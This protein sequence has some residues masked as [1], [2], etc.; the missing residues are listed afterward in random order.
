MNLGAAFKRLVGARAGSWAGRER[1]QLG[2]HRVA[3]ADFP[4]LGSAERTVGGIAQLLQL[5]RIKFA[6]VSRLLVE[7][8][9]A[10]ADATDLLDE[11]ADLLEHFAQF[12]VTA[13]DEN[14][15]VPGIVALADLADA[16]R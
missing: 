13:L 4:G 14:D 8:Q 10:V 2:V 6:Q 15:F 16:G 12:A 11:V 7:D 9:G 3:A 5:F 1:G